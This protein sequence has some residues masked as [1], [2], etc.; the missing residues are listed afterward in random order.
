MHTYQKYIFD[1]QTVDDITDEA[2][3]KFI[4]DYKKRKLTKVM[5]S[6]DCATFETSHFN[7]FERMC[8]TNLLPEVQKNNK[9]TIIIVDNYYCEY[10]CMKRWWIIKHFKMLNEKR[11]TNP[12]YTNDKWD[13]KFIDYLHNDID[14]LEF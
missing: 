9:L 1:F 7:D 4:D 10:E 13:W 8:G 2:L 6:Q 12:K 14:G 5:R 11:Q 3:I